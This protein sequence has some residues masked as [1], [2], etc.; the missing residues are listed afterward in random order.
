MIS[1]PSIYLSHINGGCG[2]DALV[3]GGWSFWDYFD[4]IE[5]CLNIHY[6]W[7]LPS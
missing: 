3:E 6:P 2:W 7:G 4:E 5:I 1:I